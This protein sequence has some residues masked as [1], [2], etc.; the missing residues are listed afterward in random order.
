MKKK[1]FQRKMGKIFKFGQ[2]LIKTR[3][4]LKI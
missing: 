4:N 2:N 1:I 3:P